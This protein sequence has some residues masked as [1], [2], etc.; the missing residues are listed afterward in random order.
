[1]HD[2]LTSLSFEVKLYTIKST[3]AST[4]GHNT[5]VSFLFLKAI[6]NSD[7]FFPPPLKLASNCAS[8]LQENKR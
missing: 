5:F 8:L 1:M 6:H 2:T 3:P 4:R 7:F